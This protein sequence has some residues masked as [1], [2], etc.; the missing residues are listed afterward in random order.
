MIEEEFL[1]F[2]NLAKSLKQQQDSLRTRQKEFIDGGIR[3]SYI[4]NSTDGICS[5]FE[6]CEETL[7]KELEE[8]VKKS[9]YK[10]AKKIISCLAGDIRAFESVKPREQDAEVKENIGKVETIYKSPVEIIFDNKDDYY[11]KITDLLTFLSTSIPLYKP[12]W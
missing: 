9:D 8:L 5:A 7:K 4:K 12:K 1:R 3:S 6:Q 2:Y 10:S 11:F